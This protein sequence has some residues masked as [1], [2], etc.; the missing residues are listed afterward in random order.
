[1][2]DDVSAVALHY[3]RLRLALGSEVGITAL[4]I[5][6]TGDQTRLDLD[7]LPGTAHQLGEPADISGCQ[8]AI[9]IVGSAGDKNAETP[10]LH[11]YGPDDAALT[12]AVRN[13]DP[14]ARKGLLAE[15]AFAAWRQRLADAADSLAPLTNTDA[16][17]LGHLDVPGSPLLTELRADRRRALGTHAKLTGS[18]D[19]VE[20]VV[21]RVMTDLRAAVR[22]GAAGLAQATDDLL[23]ES[24][25]LACDHGGWVDRLKLLIAAEEISAIESLA[26]AGAQLVSTTAESLSSGSFDRLLAKYESQRGHAEELTVVLREVIDRLPSTPRNPATRLVRRKAIHDMQT[27]RETVE[28]YST[29]VTVADA[30]NLDATTWDQAAEALAALD[31]ATADDNKEASSQFDGRSTQSAEEAAVA[32]GELFAEQLPVAKALLDDLA[33]QHPGVDAEGRIQIIKRQAVRKLAAGSRHRDL[34]QP[35]QEVVAELAMSIALLRGFEPHTEAE[36]QDL[37]RRILDRAHKIANLQAQAGI[38]LPVAIDGLSRFAQQVQPLVAE[39]VFHKLGGIK[40]H[41]P[42]VPRDAYKTM[43]SKVW[44][45]RYDRGVTAAATSSAS[46]AVMKAIDAGAPRLI[47]R[48][49]DRSLPAPKRVGGRRALL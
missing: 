1:M 2:P 49:V 6:T 43:R 30:P 23:A 36:F 26:V 24:V 12:K 27:L 41:G 22:F 3:G 13:V 17:I 39:Y 10:A 35:I 8:E 14:N 47:V 18:T 44:R 48:H 19:G 33:H 37:G 21:D 42:G 25:H 7:D 32:L 45:A 16:G 34:R 4:E 29:I 15:A 5:V 28:A 31:S 11:T 20:T 40:P 46:N 9:L 38:A